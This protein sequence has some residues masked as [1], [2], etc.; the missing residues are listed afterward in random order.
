MAGVCLP[1][2]KSALVGVLSIERREGDEEGLRVWE[3]LRET[4]VGAGRR[5]LRRVR[6]SVLEWTRERAATSLAFSLC[7]SILIVECEL[8]HVPEAVYC[9]GGSGLGF[10]LATRP[11]IQGSDLLTSKLQ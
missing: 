7:S 1:I 11:G 2:T 3:T 6:V 5:S 10:F 4:Q 9:P 8:Q